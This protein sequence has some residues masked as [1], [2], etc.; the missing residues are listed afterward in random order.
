[1]GFTECARVIIELIDSDGI[2]ERD[3]KADNDGE[4]EEVLEEE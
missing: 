2:V 4:Q 3:T 1:V